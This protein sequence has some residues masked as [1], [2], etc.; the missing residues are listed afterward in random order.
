[1]YSAMLEALPKGS[2]REKK[3][4]QKIY[5]YLVSR[6]GDRVVTEYLC[7]GDKPEAKSFEE[8]NPSSKA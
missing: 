2:L 3:I 6:K 7:Q 5:F 1:M 4:G 8:Q